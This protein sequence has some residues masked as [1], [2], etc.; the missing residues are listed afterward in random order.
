[1]PINEA[2]NSFVNPID[3]SCNTDSDCKMAQIDCS[4][5][6]C[7]SK[8]TAVNIN[9]KQPF[10]PIPEPLIMYGCL[11]CAPQWSMS[12][13]VCENNQCVEKNIT[14]VGKYE[15]LYNNT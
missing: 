3:K 5:C 14:V 7:G 1:M 13:A 9:Y 4:L 6:S 12:K 10:C 15:N 11:A 8:G 2:L